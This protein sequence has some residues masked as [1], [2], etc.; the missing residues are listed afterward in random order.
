MPNNAMQ[1]ATAKRSGIGQF[2]TFGLGGEVYAMTIDNVR[3]IIEFDGLTTMPMMPPFLRGVI[4]LRGAVVPVVDLKERFGKGCTE[5]SRRTCIVIV[6]I[7]QQG[8]S[9]NL[10][11]MVD[12]VN[13]VVEVDLSHLEAKPSFGTD[14]RQDFI[15]GI[16]DLGG[17]FVVVLDVRQVLSV[18]EMAAMVAA[19][20]RIEAGAEEARE[21]R[22]AA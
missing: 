8:R 2:L 4:N 22:A 19:G 21:Q 11:V 9:S 13:E 18:S 10:G 5:I 6:E 20:A 12:A 16:L 7:E 15:D 17:R 14:L 3:E 1:E